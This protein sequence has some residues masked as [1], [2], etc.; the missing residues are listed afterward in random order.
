MEI[1]RCGSRDPRKPSNR[2]FCYNT[3]TNVTHPP[4]PPTRTPLTTQFG[5][6][7]LLTLSSPTYSRHTSLFSSTT[8]TGAAT[9]AKHAGHLHPN[10]GVAGWNDEHTPWIEGEMMIPASAA[11]RNSSAGVEGRRKAN[12]AFVVLGRCNTQFYFFWLLNAPHF[13]FEH[14]GTKLLIVRADLYALGMV[15]EKLR[16]LVIPRLYETDGRPVQPLGG[17]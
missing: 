6:H 3:P 14:A 11:Q 15:S 17:V 2:P 7:L 1:P 4:S 10:A 12:A 5:L 8:S 9:A 16:P 13:H